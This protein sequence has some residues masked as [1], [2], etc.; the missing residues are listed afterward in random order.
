MF[1]VQMTA[2]DNQLKNELY[3][4]IGGVMNNVVEDRKRENDLPYLLSKTQLS[5]HIFNVSIP[6]LENHILHRR[7]F[8]KFE[9]G[10]RTLYPRDE[11]IEWIRANSTTLAEIPQIRKPSA[12]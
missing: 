9:I 11:V 1:S 5:E 8:P 12:V 7:G 4:L 3:D 10:G 2:D 6:S